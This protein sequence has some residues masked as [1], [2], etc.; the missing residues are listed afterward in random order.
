MLAAGVVAPCAPGSEPGQL[1]T[2]RL[3][4]TH[5]L[6]RLQN[7]SPATVIQSLGY[8][9]P[10]YQE[11]AILYGRQSKCWVTLG[12]LIKALEL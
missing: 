9:I 10:L 4:L 11:L 1:G 7:Y 12:V 3:R 6:E 2:L 8:E 5:F